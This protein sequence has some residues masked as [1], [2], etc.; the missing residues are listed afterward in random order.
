ME[1]S[2]RISERARL[3]PPSPI[4]KLVPLADAAKARGIRV[5]HLNIGQPDLPTPNPMW[6]AVR[7]YP[8]PVL[9]YAPSGGLPEFVEALAGYY[10][11]LGLPVRPEEILVTTAASEALVFALATLADP[12]DE[13]LIPEPL[14]ANYVGF[15]RL[16]GLRPVPAPCAP[17]D[18]YRIPPPEVLDRHAS[19][20]TRVLILCNPG[21]PTGCVTA[22]EELLELAAWARRRGIF[23]IG[24]EVYREFCYTAR[25]APSLLSLEGY[26]DRVVVVD[27]LSKRFSAC[28]ARVG[29][30]VTRNA[31]VRAAVL[32]FAQARLSPP[33]LGQL[34]GL[35][36]LRELGPDY[37]EE[38]R[39]IYR[40]RRDALCAAL[41]EIPGVRLRVP[42]GAFY[43]M[44]TLPVADSEDFAR[45]LLADFSDD[46]ETVM[47]APGPGFY[48]TPGGGRREVRIAYVLEEA[49]LVRCA[50]I[51]RR[52]LEV[53]PGRTG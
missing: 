52:A 41:Q 9:S 47:V 8:G 43:L 39:R 1:S 42:E 31:E 48:L 20:K 7:E 27:S 14:Y 44:V 4:R 21:N 18:G 53:Y 6:Q 33:T 2:T 35:R 11:G 17:E 40:G 22:R 29:C 24:D 37:Y 36:A 25:V 5:H 30:L 13:V 28:G 26:E 15:S 49:K 10:E 38:V 45:W 12:G 50:A 34:M 51:L 16:L 23:L 3:A 32:K 19:P 46:G